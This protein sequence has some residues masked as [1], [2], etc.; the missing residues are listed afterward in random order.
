MLGICKTSDIGVGVCP[1]HDSPVTYV[2]TMTVG[3][4][5]VRTNNLPTATLMTIGMSSCGHP[6]V[7]ITCSWNVRAQNLGVHRL[8]DIGVNC[9]PY[10]MVTSSWN[11]RN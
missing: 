9:G 1:C 6:T 10:T 2:T 5:S 8:N 3:A 11:V 4:Y 7:A